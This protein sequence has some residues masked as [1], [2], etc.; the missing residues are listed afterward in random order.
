M[1]QGSSQR[2]DSLQKMILLSR[3]ADVAVWNTYFGQVLIGVI[4]TVKDPDP[5]VR[6]L[7]LLC[8]KEM[9][10]HQSFHFAE[11][12]NI[13]V[14]NI[15][16]G[17]RDENKDV[18]HAAEESFE[19]LVLSLNRFRCLEVLRPIIATEDGKVLQVSIRMLSKLVMRFSKEDLL[20]RVSELLPGLYE[21]FKHPNADVRKAVVFCLVDMYLVMGDDFS[22]YLAELST[23]QLKLVTIYINRTAKIRT[24]QQTA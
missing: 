13:T 8:V 10:S 16:E 4:G 14:T 7:G 20:P 17:Y 24:E 21:A 15:L 9:L 2:R 6:E 23:S 5:S 11:F 22:P 1:Q 3:G 12:V 19:Q 18:A